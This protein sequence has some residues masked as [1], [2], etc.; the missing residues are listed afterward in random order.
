MPMNEENKQPEQPPEDSNEAPAVSPSPETAKK[1]SGWQMPEPKFQ[2]TSGYLPQG[3][4]NE[5][6]E[7]GGFSPAPG[8]TSVG[9]ETGNAQPPEQLPDNFDDVPVPADVPAAEEAGLSDLTMFN[10]AVPVNSAE[11]AEPEMPEPPT[12]EPVA[13]VEPQPDLADVIEAADDKGP[14]IAS[15]VPPKGGGALKAFLFI[16]FFLGLGVLA[17][18]IVALAYYLFLAEN[19]AG[20]NF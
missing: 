19:G 10:V 17:L 16:L 7:A 6:N 14:A 3:Y 18:V 15:P 13:D 5:I 2:Q 11:I 8:V 12:V 4:I 20:R 1:S 9:P